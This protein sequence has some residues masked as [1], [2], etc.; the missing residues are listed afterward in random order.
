M[1]F[2]VLLLAF[3]SVSPL[4]NLD[5]IQR[6]LAK[7]EFEKASELLIKAKSKESDN[8]GIDYLAAFLFSRDAFIEFNLDTARVLVAT[9]IK[10]FETQDKDLLEGLRND[11]ITLEKASNLREE[12]R[13]RIYAN[14][15][16]ELSIARAESFMVL[17]PNSPYEESL[18]YRRDSIV[19][20]QVRRN[21][22]LGLYESFLKRYETTEFR[23]IAEKRIDELRFQGLTHS[24]KLPDYYEFLKT[25]PDTQF[26]DQIEQ[27]IFKVSTADQTANSYLD[28]LSFA[29]NNQLKKKAADILHYLAKG[30]LD[31]FKHPKTDSLATV[32]QNASLQLFPTLKDGSFGF[33]SLAGKLVVPYSFENVSA[34]YKCQ[35]TADEW[36]F[37]TGESEGMIVNKSGLALVKK[38]DEYVDLG[39]GIAKVRRNGAWQLYHKSGFK[40]LGENIDDAKVLK[41]RWLAVK[42]NGKWAL[43]SFSGHEITDYRFDD[44]HLEADY[45][46]FERDGLI[47]VHTE[48]L[49]ASAIRKDGLELEFKFEDLELIT[50]KMLIGF[51]GDRECMFDENLSFLIP[52]GAYEINPDP[53]GWYLKTKDGFRLYD[54]ADNDIMSKS[55]PYLETGKEWL[56]LKS[57]LD[58]ALISRTEGTEPTRGYDSLR[59]INE[60]A[61]FAR[62]GDQLSLIFPGEKII[63]IDSSNEIKTFYNRADYLLLASEDSMVLLDSAGQKILE[64]SF[65]EITFFNDSLLSVK[66]EGKKGLLNLQGI[67]VVPVSFDVIDENN[68]LVLCL[69]DGKIGCFDLLNNIVI[70]PISESR[71][72][73]VGEN[74]LVKS[75]EK[76]GLVDSLE[77]PVLPFEYDEIKYWNDSSYLTRVDNEWSFVNQHAELIGE[78]VGFLTKLVS[79]E[80]ESIWKYVSDGKYGLL[81]NR[82][83]VLLEPEFTDIFNIGDEQTPVFFADQH[84][85]KAGY[86]V[87]SYVNMKGDL[88]LSKAYRKTEFEKILCD[89]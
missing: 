58:W 24:G 23:K 40:I 32:L 30:S 18:I 81:S 46:I 83:G 42:R 54:H 69:E 37:V 19:F 63:P 44:I 66:R 26:R 27:F 31:N 71:I 36:L 85:D 78:S 41:A 67:E 48:E 9:A 56:V 51:R 84:L 11:Q 1:R 72:E 13:D 64:G 14:T 60:F 62:T 70:S 47:A 53:S 86:H 22:E 21:D 45:W 8:P 79:N 5:R 29:T 35:L 80:E 16:S 65:D 15:L 74:Y 33:H 6:A 75:E 57:E 12:I 87:V 4:G 50:E 34:D 82:M 43:V 17:Y 49:I 73:R 77:E 52:W 68:G 28:F 55:H 76:Y 3:L 25:H 59:L 10:N 7:M 39:T 61:V 38:V 20:D 89:D 2:V 88:I